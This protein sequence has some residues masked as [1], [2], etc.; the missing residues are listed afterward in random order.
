M[1]GKKH[2]VRAVNP[3]PKAAGRAGITPWSKTKTGR[4]I[5]DH[6][7]GVRL[8]VSRVPGTTKKRW[9]V[10]LSY[11]GDRAKEEG[12]G[13]KGY[14]GNRG[15]IVQDRARALAW[16]SENE[17]MDAAQQ[18]L[19]GAVRAANPNLKRIRIDRDP[20]CVEPY[21][22]T[23]GTKVEGYC[24]PET[25]YTMEDPGKPG[26]RSRGAKAGPF[27][28][29]KGYEP[30]IQ[31]EG[32]LGGPGYT[33]KPQKKRREILTKCVKQFGY[34]SCLGSV[35]VLLRNSEISKKTRKVLES[36]KA[37]L[38][39]TYGGPG[40]FGPQENPVAEGTVVMGIIGDSNPIEHTGGVVYDAGYG[41]HVIYFQPY[42][43]RVSIYTVPI[44]DNVVNDL[45]WVDWKAVSEYVDQTYGDL[46]KYGRSSSPVARAT[47]IEAAGGYHGWAE[48]DPDP[49]DMTIQAAEDLYGDLVDAAHRSS[50]PGHASSRE[51]RKIKN[52]VLR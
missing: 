37:W 13:V 32:K 16:T 19:E 49:Q 40:S 15:M 50:N 29:S 8:T 1:A 5:T 31:R 28:A 48:M 34:R 23:D 24:V 26:R 35:M 17:A 46:A 47:V 44:D 14:L 43:D 30:W 2:K 3:A 36:D 18:A 20:Y 33:E 6:D 45:N 52:R 11:V 41:P 12:K 22:K 25:T 39:K 10:K 21:T 42:Q 4:H 27:S 38:M 7:S 51:V 9:Y